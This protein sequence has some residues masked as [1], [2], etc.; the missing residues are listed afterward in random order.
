MPLF[1]GIKY[2][3]IHVANLEISFHFTRKN[4]KKYKEI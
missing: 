3:K 2:K 4:K 1:D